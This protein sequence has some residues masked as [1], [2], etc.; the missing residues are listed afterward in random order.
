[1]DNAAQEVKKIRTDSL[2]LVRV[3]VANVWWV[4]REGHVI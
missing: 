4:L 1:M 2:P 3:K